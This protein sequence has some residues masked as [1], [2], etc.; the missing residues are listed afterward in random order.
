MLFA[1]TKQSQIVTALIQIA[2]FQVIPLPADTGP[3]W[4]LLFATPTMA[5]N[6][7]TE[8]RH[9]IVTWNNDL[10]KSP[11]ECAA[12]AKYSVRR[13]SDAQSLFV[14][15]AGSHCEIPERRGRPLQKTQMGASA[16]R[17][18]CSTSCRI[19]RLCC[20]GCVTTYL[21]RTNNIFGCTTAE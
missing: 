3:G 15:A 14:V 8:M 19:T 2:S 17:E 9:N 21:A 4:C 5:P 13:S 12:L 6:L 7:S 20:L 16:K 11:S 10:Q 1:S 18:I